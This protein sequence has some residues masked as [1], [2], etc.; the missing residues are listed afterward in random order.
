[1]SLCLAYH[2]RCCAPV[3][4]PPHHHTTKRHHCLSAAQQMPC[5]FTQN[6]TWAAAGGGGRDALHMA[7]CTEAGTGA[8]DATTVR[9]A[10][11]DRLTKLNTAGRKLNTAGRSTKLNTADSS[12][13]RTWSPVPRACA[14]HRPP[15]LCAL[16]ASVL[17]NA[18]SALYLA[19]ITTEYGSTG[20]S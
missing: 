15:E 1:M 14:M 13:L 20:L 11:M 6:D 17:A 9:T 3:E 5:A 8:G 16:A 4:T 18:A 10:V 7:G 19:H 12:A 2:L